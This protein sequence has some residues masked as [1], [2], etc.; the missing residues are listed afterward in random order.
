ERD[1]V[2]GDLDVSLAEGRD[3]VARAVAVVAGTEPGEIDEANGDR[4]RPGTRERFRVEIGDEL[5]ADRRE[6]LAETD[7][8]VELRLLLRGAVPHD[9]HACRGVSRP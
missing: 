4:T 9:R 6:G 8:L 7:E 3:A 5:G 1:L 2:A